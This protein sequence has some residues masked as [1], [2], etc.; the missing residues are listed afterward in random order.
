MATLLNS[1]PFFINAAGDM[2]ILSGGSGGSGA[3]TITSQNG[4]GG[5]ITFDSDNNISLT[6]VT[7][8]IFTNGGFERARMTNAGFFGI[9]TD[10]PVCQLHIQKG[11]AIPYVVDGNAVV[12]LNSNTNATNFWFNIGA[13]ATNATFGFAVDGVIKH[14]LS[15]NRLNDVLALTNQGVL[16]SPTEGLFVGSNGNIGIH[17]QPDP[18]APLGVLGHTRYLMTLLTDV[19]IDGSDHAEWFIGF[20]NATD[21]TNECI[22]FDFNHEGGVNSPLNFCSFHLYGDSSGNGLSVHPDGQVGIGTGSNQITASAKLEISSTTQGVIFPILTMAER[23]A[24]VTP[25]SG[26]M[27]YNDTTFALEVFD[28]TQWVSWGPSKRIKDVNSTPYT[29]NNADVVLHVSYSATG[30]ASIVLPTAQCYNGRTITIKDGGLYCDV[31][32]ITVSTQG[33]E[34]IDGLPTKIMA[35]RG[36]SILLYAM[37]GNWYL[38]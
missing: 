23:N 7:S 29:V 16:G 34:L 18:N 1:M 33:A 5:D 35:S 32:N 19:S 21:A 11:A 12:Q 28:G 10:V 20:Y 24:I 22:A 25:A 37:G 36:Q 27:I 13:A 30:A 31:N 26:L 9:G 8:T 38:F 4:S 15:Y 17:Q 2:S 6:T 3:I 14:G